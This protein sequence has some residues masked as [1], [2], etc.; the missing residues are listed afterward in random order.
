MQTAAAPSHHSND[1]NMASPDA[2]EISREFM[3]PG[4][5]LQTLLLVL[6]H[7]S[8][9]ACGRLDQ[10]QDRTASDFSEWFL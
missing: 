6:H 4:P 3:A 7:A 10:G 9:C 1:A 8:P 5:S 2:P